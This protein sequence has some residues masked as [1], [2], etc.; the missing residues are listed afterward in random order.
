MYLTATQ[1]QVAIDEVKRL[2]I[3]GSRNST[4]DSYGQKKTGGSLGKGIKA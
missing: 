3:G 4:Y 2:L 1:T